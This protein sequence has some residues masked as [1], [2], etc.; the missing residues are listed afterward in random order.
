[1]SYIR[2]DQPSRWQVRGFDENRPQATI[3]K[4]NSGRFVYWR[5]H[6]QMVVR[7]QAV[8][9][10]YFETIQR[11]QQEIEQLKQQLGGV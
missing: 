3:S 4:S 6:A 7:L 2:E 11:Q 5:D 1:M 10:T 9:R 8:N